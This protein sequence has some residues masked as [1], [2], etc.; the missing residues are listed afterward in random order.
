MCVCVTL[1]IPLSP[2][3]FQHFILVAH[4]KFT[5]FTD[6][7]CA[8]RTNEEKLV[9][10]MKWE[11]MWISSSASSSFYFYCFDVSFSYYFASMG[12]M[13][14]TINNCCRSIHQQQKTSKWQRPRRRRRQ[15]T[16]GPVSVCVKYAHF[17]LVSLFCHRTAEME[18]SSKSIFRCL[19]WRPLRTV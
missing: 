13:S 4:R 16:K 5:D 9:F 3:H 8:A 19:R 7:W 10:A 12:A 6:R 14:K 17:I 15:S 2:Y 11:R 1:T 18:T